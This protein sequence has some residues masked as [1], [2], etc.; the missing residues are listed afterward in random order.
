MRGML[1]APERRNARRHTILDDITRRRFLV[2]G[3]AALLLGAAGCGSGGGSGGGEESSQTRSI[4]HKYGTTEIPGAPERVV[5]VGYTDQDPL[6][7]FGTRPTGIREW[8][9]VQEYAVWPW[10]EEE[11]GDAEPRMLSVD[12]INYEQVAALE[13]DLIIGVSSGMTRDDYDSLSEFAPTLPQSDEYVDFGVPWQDQ[14]RVIGRALGKNERAERLISDLEQKFENTREEYPAFEGATVSVLGEGEGTFYFYTPLDRSVRFFQS[15][16]FEIPEEARELSRS[17][18]FSVEISE[19]QFSLVEADVVIWFSS[20]ASHEE[21]MKNN[22]VYGK[23]RAAREGRDIFL[24]SNED[25]IKAALS[26]NT[27]LSHPYLL[28]NFAGKLAETIQ[29]A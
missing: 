3:G 19:E 5:S 26:F 11:L 4:E 1:R 16:G 6:L 12:S 27:V 20:T 24:D 14:T 18:Q 23:L 29:R 25:P 2:G 8:L 13:P 10:A 15:L 7:A 22:E 21:D 28:D 9:G 17:E